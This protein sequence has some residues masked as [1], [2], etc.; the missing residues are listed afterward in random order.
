MPFHGSR[1]QDEPLMM[2]LAEAQHLIY[3]TGTKEA[4]SNSKTVKSTRKNPQ[5]VYEPQFLS[6][7]LILWTPEETT[8]FS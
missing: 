1:L 5:T 7:S 4:Y 6:L 2:S 8:E 3:I